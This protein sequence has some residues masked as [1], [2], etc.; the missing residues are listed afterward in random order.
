MSKKRI[1]SVLTMMLLVISSLNMS[2]YATTT[3]SVDQKLMKIGVPEEL[4]RLMSEEQKK[5]ISENCIEFVD[6]QI[7][8]APINENGTT[9]DS[10]GTLGTISETKLTQFISVLRSNNSSDNRERFSIYANFDWVSMPLARFTDP[11]G[12]SWSQNWRAVPGTSSMTT[13]VKWSYSTSFSL[14]ENSTAL[15]YTASTGCG[16]NTNMPAYTNADDFYGYGKI[17]IESMTPGSITGSDQLAQNYFHTTG[18]GS[19]G[20]NLG[21]IT[22][23]F[24]GTSGY[25][26]QGIYGNFS[27]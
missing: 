16:W 7:I 11:F 4:I 8:T 22:M 17:T 21:V 12:I 27:Y 5:D 3:K 13:F 26:S 9:S 10:I 2:T 18:I 15:G 20:I 24:S 6:Y 1:I 23:S 14:W 25:D 19:I